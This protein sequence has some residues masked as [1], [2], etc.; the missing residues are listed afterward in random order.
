MS[1]LVRTSGDRPAAARGSR[2]GPGRV[3]GRAALLST[4][5]LLS[6]VILL[7]QAGRVG[8]AG[9]GTP[10]APAPTVEETLTTPEAVAGLHVVHKVSL[11]GI[12]CFSKY[13]CV[14][15]GVRTGFPGIPGDKGVV[16]TITDGVPGPVEVVR[17]TYGLDSVDC[18]SATTCYA[19]GTA[20]FV[21]PPEPKTTGGVEVTIVNGA[22]TSV[23]DAGAPNVGP[24]GPGTEDLYGIGCPSP[25]FCVAVGFSNVVGGFAVEASNGEPGAQQNFLLTGPYNANGIEC[26]TGDSCMVNAETMEPESN[27][28]VGFDE[29]V[30]PARH[31]DL[32]VGKE[33]GGQFGTTLGGGSCHGDD[34][35]FCLIAGSAGSHG[36]P[37]QGSHGLVYVAVGI[38]STR[39]V[40]VPNTSSLS[41]V[42]CASAYWC[43]AVGQS[44]SGEGVLV[45]IGWETPAAPVPVTRTTGFNAVS[46]VPTGLCVAVG[47]TKVDSFRVWKG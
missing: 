47:G 17:G 11:E 8:A 14:A 27:K 46:C 12:S 15:V 2:P 39:D 24:G 29:V 3:Q 1:V 33:E 9:S 37:I 41:D 32:A 30:T 4:L 38:A 13:Q 40:T 28:I 10:G 45:P 7:G 5:F 31:G 20:H 36:I 21:N 19:V 42:S 6:V 18:V 44:T 34:I 22:V 25:T 16:V 23:A 26:V 35:E 43:I